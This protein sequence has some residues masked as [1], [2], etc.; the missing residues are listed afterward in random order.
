MEEKSLKTEADTHE[1]TP[2]ADEQAPK[3]SKDMAPVDY[4]ALLMEQEHR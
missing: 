3:T 4:L 2:E 1:V